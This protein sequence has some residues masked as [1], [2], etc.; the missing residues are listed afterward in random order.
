MTSRSSL[1]QTIKRLIGYFQNRSFSNELKRERTKKY[2]YQ[3]ETKHH[4]WI[5]FYN[6]ARR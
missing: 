6:K 1:L 4:G 2:L 3:N 5:H